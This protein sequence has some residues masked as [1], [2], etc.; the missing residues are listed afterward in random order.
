MTWEMYW[1]WFLKDLEVRTYIWL[2]LCLVL[3]VWLLVM[4]LK[5]K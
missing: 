2:G 3:G 1:S 4:Y 5:K